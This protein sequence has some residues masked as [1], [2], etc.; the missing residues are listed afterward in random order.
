MEV[1]IALLAWALIHAYSRVYL[2]A[3]FPY[4]SLI[5]AALGFL[6]ATLITKVFMAGGDTAGNGAH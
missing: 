5:G 6:M 2:A 1:K 3:H 4:C